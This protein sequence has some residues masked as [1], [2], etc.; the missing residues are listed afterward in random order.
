MR[1]CRVRATGLGPL[2]FVLLAAATAACSDGDPVGPVPGSPGALTVDATTDWAF[3]SLGENATELQVSDPTSSAAWHLAFRT[4]GVMLN[5]GAAGPGGVEGYCLCQNENATDQQLLDMTPQSEQSL[6][7]IV[8]PADI[9]ADADAWESDALAPAIDGWWNYDMATHTVTPASD[10]TWVVRTA[11]GTAYA[12]LRVVEI[13]NATQQHAGSVTLE[14]AVQP[15]TGEPYGDPQTLTVD[16]SSGPA[17]VDLMEGGVSDAADWD[18]QFEGYTIR[19][20]GG[21]SGSGEAVATEAET[22]FDSVPDAGE[23]DSRAFATDSFGGVFEAHPWYR[24]DIE[25]NHQVW[26]NYNVYLIRVGEEVYKVQLTGYYNP[27][28]GEARHITFRYALLTD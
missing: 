25:G 4:T 20:N 18:I 7:D 14:F 27:T 16:L 11:E 22:D 2:S 28:D 26:P 9:P 23:I 13:E 17:Y 5:G 6:F 3:V 24:Y 10:R 19:L 15:A 8:T 12:K 1:Q 21:V